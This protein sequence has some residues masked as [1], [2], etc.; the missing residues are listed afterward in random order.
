[1]HAEELNTSSTTA[2]EYCHCWGSICHLT[3]AGFSVSPA[4]ILCFCFFNS[5]VTFRCYLLMFLITEQNERDRNKYQLIRLISICD[6]S[7]LQ[8]DV[9]CHASKDRRTGPSPAVLHRHGHCA[10]GQQEIQVPPSH[11][12]MTGSG[13][14]V[15]AECPLWTHSQKKNQK[16]SLHILKLCSSPFT[17]G[18]N[19]EM[20]PRVPPLNCC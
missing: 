7:P 9:S 17:D 19:A 6:F 5:M 18:P 20:C 1:M 14:T 15:L 8:E 16:P 13:M 3:A 11:W 10:R 2:S 12:C 4:A